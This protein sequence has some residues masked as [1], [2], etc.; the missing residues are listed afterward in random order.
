MSAKLIHSSTKPLKTEAPKRFDYKAL[1]IRFNWQPYT[2]EEI[3]LNCAGSKGLN[4]FLKS[5]FKK[6]LKELQAS[7]EELKKVA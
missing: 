1:G 5:N 6:R 2:H 4:D 7:H 3:V